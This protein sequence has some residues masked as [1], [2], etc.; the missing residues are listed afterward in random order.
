MITNGY[1]LKNK[2][3]PKFGAFHNQRMTFRLQ[4]HV[5]DDIIW[6]QKTL[7]SKRQKQDQGRWMAATMLF[8]TKS[9]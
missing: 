4:S 6:V 5:H 9:C 8:S 7:V 2:H 3:V 1:N